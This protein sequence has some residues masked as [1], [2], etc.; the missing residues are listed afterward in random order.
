M[1]LGVTYEKHRAMQ[2]INPTNKEKNTT[3][4]WQADVGA[5]WKLTTEMVLFVK[6][7]SQL[8]CSILFLTLPS[9]TVVNLGD[10]AMYVHTALA[11]WLVGH[12]TAFAYTLPPPSTSLVHPNYPPP[13]L[14][15]FDASDW[16]FAIHISLP[17]RSTWDDYACSLNLN[18]SV[19]P[20]RVMDRR[21]VISLVHRRSS[22]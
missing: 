7:Y 6:R 9:P 19:C 16:A 3:G 8:W 5:D 18:R 12:V 4:L 11:A 22:S 1:H 15:C 17:V 10:K 20:S 14:H 21:R 2:N 13:F